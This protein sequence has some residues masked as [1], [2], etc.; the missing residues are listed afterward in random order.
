MHL[1]AYIGIGIFIIA[2]SMIF[3]ILKSNE[4]NNNRPY[5]FSLVAFGLIILHWL[6]YLFEFYTIIPENIADII[7]LPAWIAASVIG[8]IAARKEFRNNRAFSIVNG[9]L[10]II[11]LTLGILVWGIGNM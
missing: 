8:F 2:I 3:F 9:G 5:L 10:S 1:T 11:T 6:L 4:K 7:F